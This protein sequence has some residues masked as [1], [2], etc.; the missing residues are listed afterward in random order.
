MTVDG[1]AKAMKTISK[2]NGL[3]LEVWTKSQIC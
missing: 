1:K 2:L 3:D